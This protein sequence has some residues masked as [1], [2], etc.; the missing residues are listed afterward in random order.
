ML[1]SVRSYGPCGKK[2]FFVRSE[3]RI[4]GFFAHRLHRFSQI[5]IG[6]NISAYPA[7]LSPRSV[8]ILL[9]YQ[10]YWGNDITDG[11]ESACKASTTQP[12]AARRRRRRFRSKAEKER[13][14]R[15]GDIKGNCAL[16]GQNHQTCPKDAVLGRLC[17]RSALWDACVACRSKNCYIIPNNQH[18]SRQ[19]M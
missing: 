13:P 3:A 4:L 2:L 18:Y 5:I 15:W 7:D 12:R 10:Y 6:Y 8:G 16:Q 17:A 1:H 9:Y 11:T 14:G 19:N